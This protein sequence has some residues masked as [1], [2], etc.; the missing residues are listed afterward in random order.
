[1][2]GITP[3]QREPHKGSKFLSQLVGER[4]REARSLHNN[5]SQHDVAERMELLGHNWVRQTMAR[6]ESADRNLTVDELVSLAI[7]LQ[8]SVAYLLS[9]ASPADPYT[10]DPVD[11][12]GPDPLGR[13]EL[14][15]LFGFPTDPFP[16]ARGYYEWPDM[17]FITARSWDEVR[18]GTEAEDWIKQAEG[19]SDEQ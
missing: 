12:G 19:T 3:A 15:A 13:D 14:S 10:S 4:A 16:R 11:I 6:I 8:T 7:A 2:P 5:L 17:T 9:P 18:F 1:M